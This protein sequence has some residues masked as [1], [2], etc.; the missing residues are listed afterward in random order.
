MHEINII[1][2][3]S[4]SHRAAI[5]GAMAEG[6]T[7]IVNFGFCK[8]TLAT[9]SCLRALGIKVTRNKNNVIIRSAGYQKLKEPSN[10][11][12]AGNSASTMRILM[13]LLAGSNF[14]TVLNGD[15]SLRARPMKRV[16][17]PLREMGACIYAREDEFPPVFVKGGTLKSISYTSPIVSAQVKTAVLFAGAQADG[18]TT[19]KEPIGS[20]NHTELMLP[21]FGCKIFT[22]TDVKGFTFTSVKG[23]D[24]IYGQQVIVPGDFSAASFFIAGAVLLKNNPLLI[25]NVGLNQTRTGLLNVLIKMGANI[26]IVNKYQMNAEDMGDIF[27]GANGCS[28]MK[29]INLTPDMIPGIID[30]IPILAVCATQVQ[31]TTKFTGQKA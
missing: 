15:N 21:Y 14:M 4:I 27:V 28:E 17:L 26:K 2:D 9:L 6:T 1:G 20:R 24:N 25:K 29:G 18:I 19:Y 8:D 30:E 31:G 16:V 13:G 7:E 3:K 12:Y 10:I 5:L 22:D 11:L 23:K